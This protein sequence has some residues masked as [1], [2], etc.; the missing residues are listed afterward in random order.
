MNTLLP[1]PTKSPNFINASVAFKHLKENV[2]YIAT[3]GKHLNNATL[4]GL[5]DKS[6][7]C[8][9]NAIGNLPFPSCYAMKL[10]ISAFSRGLIQKF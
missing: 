4:C 6:E 3:L 2:L 8:E 5:E 10:E 9:N 1:Y 7:Y